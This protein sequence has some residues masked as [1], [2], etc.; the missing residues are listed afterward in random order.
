[1]VAAVVGGLVVLGIV[2]AVVIPVYLNQRAENVARHTTFVL[3][4]SIAGA[5]RMDGNI[6]QTLQMQMSALPPGWAAPQ[7]AAYGT[8]TSVR[9]VVVGGLHYIP[10]EHRSEFL[11]GMLS[12]TVA[13]GT[14]V[15]DTPSGPLGG[16]MKCFETAAGRATTCAFADGGAW[17]VIAVPGAGAAAHD[18][19][20]AAR[21]AIEHHP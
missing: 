6:Q 4:A 14:T 17:G 18:Q 2:A 1:V 16:T 13:Q 21:A 5:P 3:P 20:L 15:T 11:N 10:A 12:S 19:I 9:A 7:A 8:G